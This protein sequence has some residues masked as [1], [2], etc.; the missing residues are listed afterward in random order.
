MCKI[1]VMFNLFFFRHFALRLRKLFTFVIN[2][3]HLQ[4]NKDDNTV[5]KSMVR[6]RSINNFDL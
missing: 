1:V 4:C 2:I 5:R 6:L 3:A